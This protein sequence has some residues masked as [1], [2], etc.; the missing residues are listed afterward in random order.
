TLQETIAKHNLTPNILE[1]LISNQLNLQ[2][3]G[4]TTQ[5]AEILA[6]ELA[7]RG[8]NPATASA[9]MAQL[10]QESRDLED[11]KNKAEAEAKKRSLE[12]NGL[13]RNIEST[14][15]ELEHGKEQVQKLEE[16]YNYRKELLSKEY[17]ALE[18]KLQ[19]EH[20][21]KKQNTQAEIEGLE[22]RAKLLKTEVEDL[23]S[24]K[25]FISIA[26]DDLETIQ[27]SI[28]RSKPLSTL[29][30]LIENPA[31]LKSVKEVPEVMLAILSGFKN[32]LGE[33]NQIS[34]KN[35]FNLLD[36]VKGLTKVLVEELP[37]GTVKT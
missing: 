17:Q 30:S 21:L 6:Q 24:T 20:D 2:K 33:S 35:K 36:P 29:V 32:Y 28:N 10:L 11:A 18:S 31:A 7:K 22:K 34:L 12:L 37:V 4:F 3:L 5:Q 23:Q 26:E 19:A 1:H 14:K 27:Q 9:Q 16:S 13:T 8:L 25:A 15:E